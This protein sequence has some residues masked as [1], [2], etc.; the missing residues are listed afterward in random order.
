MTNSRAEAAYRRSVAAFRNPTLDLLHGRQAPFVVTALSIVFTPD[1]P[2]VAIADAHAEITE[3]LEQLRSAGVGDDEL[4]LPSVPARELCGHWVKVGWLVRQI[5][6]ETEVYRLSAH[7][8]G[9]LEIAGRT[10]G[11]GARVSSSRV[12]TLLDAVERLAND[13]E[14]DRDAQLA[15]LQAERDALDAEIGRLL[16]GGEP[17]AVEEEQLIE[18]AEN[19]LHLARELPAD[20]ARVAESIKAMQRDVVADLRQDIR[21]T[22]EVLREYLQRG[23]HVMEA[24]PEGRAFAGALRLIGSPEHIDQLADQLHSVLVQPFARLLDAEQRAEL[25]AIGRR[26]EQGVQEVLVAQRRASQVITAQVRTHDPVRD[27]QVDDLLRDVMSGLQAWMQAGG[28]SNDAVEP[29]RSFPV[30]DVGHLRQ[31]VSDIQPPGAPEPLRDAGDVEFVHADTRNWGGPRYREL[32][33]HVAGLGDT[34]DLAAAFEGA[35]D[36]T[37]RPVD[38]LGLLEIAHRNGMTETDDVSVATA[39]RPDGSTRR[40]AFGAVTARTTMEDSLD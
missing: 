22:G 14:S 4:R 10:S 28:R 32:E 11:G 7:A 26:V 38:L 13:A 27:R 21:P 1:R 2:A 19:V 36:E 35:T 30:A 12:R 3:V 24:T 17:E 15:R 31:S 33:E 34:F 5:D 39:I 8:V 20:F 16:A 23:Q 6:G 37:R 18:E 29:L 25:R 9:A 40:F